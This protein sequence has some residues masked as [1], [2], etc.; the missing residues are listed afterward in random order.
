MEYLD[1]ATILC[2]FVVALEWLV[3]VFFSYFCCSD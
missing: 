3:T 2:I 1:H